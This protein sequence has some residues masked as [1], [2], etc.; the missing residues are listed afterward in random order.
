MVE[1]MQ[2][3]I[4][5]STHLFNAM[6]RLDHR[7]PNAAGAILIHSEMSCEIIT[8]GYHVHPDLLGLLYRDK[9]I[10]RIVLVTDGLKPTGQEEGP[11]FANGEEVIFCDGVFRR[12]SDGIIAGSGLTMIKGIKN[13]ISGYFTLVDAVKAASLNPAQIM[14]YTQQGAIIPGKL[15]DLTV[16]DKDYNLT[17]V[18]IGGKIIGGN[19]ANYHS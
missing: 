10:D 3:G 14:R 6:S 2:V 17:L 8:D 9:P 16:F 18:M 1:G 13:L 12:V 15:A 19:N 4:L 7:N 11:F 5:H